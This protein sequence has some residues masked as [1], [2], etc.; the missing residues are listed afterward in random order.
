[1]AKLTQEELNNFPWWK[2]RG[3]WKHKKSGHEYFVVGSMI[4]ATNDKEGQI[5]IQYQRDT[6]RFIRE[7]MEFLEKFERIES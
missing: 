4:N 1:M 2:H 7:E 6:Y 5:M 3:K